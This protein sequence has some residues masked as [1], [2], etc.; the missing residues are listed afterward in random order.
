[1]VPARQDAPLNTRASGPMQA[2][3][4][5]PISIS[6][7]LFAGLAVPARCAITGTIPTS[8]RR[9]RGG[10][11]KPT[12]SRQK[13][14][15]GPYPG[16]VWKSSALVDVAVPDSAH[17]TI[18]TSRHVCYLAAFG[19]EAEISQRIAERDLKYTP[20]LG[21]G[22]EGDQDDADHFT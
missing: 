19:G 7:R 5:S 16:A 17:G 10:F 22:P 9:T 14:S 1:M 2:E 20:P 13:P 18:Q 15:W 4:A 11:R 8:A 6:A 21:S 12:Y 3:I